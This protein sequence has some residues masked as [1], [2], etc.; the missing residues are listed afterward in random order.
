MEETREQ[1]WARE[2]AEVTA[3][4]AEVAALIEQANDPDDDYDGH[5]GPDGTAE[6]YL[7]A[8]SNAPQDA[9]KIEARD[10]G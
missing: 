2:A 8:L 6:A 5:H 7:F 1:R 9:V 3:R 4:E 10:R